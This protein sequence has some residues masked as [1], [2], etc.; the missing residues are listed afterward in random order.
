MSPGFRECFKTGFVGERRFY[1]SVYL[2]FA[3]PMIIFLSF[4]QLP[5][6][7]P[8]EWSHFLRAYQVANGVFF[9]IKKA[10]EQGEYDVGSNVDQ[11]ILLL[12]LKINE[13]H[14]DKNLRM[15]KENLSELNNLSFGVETYSSTKQVS[16]YP[17]FLYLP[18]TIGVKFGQVFDLSVVKSV[19]LSRVI[20]GVISLII[21]LI[22]L[23]IARKGITIFFVLLILP[24]TLQQYASTSQDALIIA[25]AALCTAIMTRFDFKPGVR[26][27]WKQITAVIAIIFLLCTSRPPY[28][29]LSGIF[30]VFSI[31][32]WENKALR[33][34]LLVSF[35]VTV[36]AVILWALY[37]SLFVSVQFGPDGVSYRDQL[38]FIASHPFNWLGIFW[39]TLSR[40]FNGHVKELIGVLGFLDVLLPEQYYS[41]AKITLALVLV[42]CLYDNVVNKLQVKEILY[43]IGIL[44]ILFTSILGIYLVL[45]VSWTPTGHD[46]IKGAQ[47]RYFIPLVFFLSLAAA[48]QS[49]EVI[50]DSSTG[51][52]EISGIKDFIVRTALLL[53]C[54]ATV[55]VIPWTIA[56]RFY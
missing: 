40:Q 39:K 9:S 2:I 8:D 23:L 30:L 41:L 32:H 46:V 31:Y 25:L 12:S 52:L 27:S 43:K 6:Y 24:M 33:Y 14:F 29:A 56:L 4:V 7:T 11:G 13:F 54:V 55:I 26:V 35:I 15:N 28:L 50:E 1:C 51:Y 44:G 22:A 18:Q 53:F 3:L 47:G 38:A 5:L 34:Q 37:I 36:A 16:I 45:Y 21:S 49:H 20:N 48:N 42:A 19:Q 17:P 10:N